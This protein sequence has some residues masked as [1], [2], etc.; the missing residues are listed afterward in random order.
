LSCFSRGDLLWFFPVALCVAA[1][2]AAGVVFGGGR[3][4]GGRF[5]L[6]CIVQRVRVLESW[7]RFMSCLCLWELVSFSCRGVILALFFFIFI[8]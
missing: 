8:P 4:H 5:G 1:L 7:L 3:R 6:G 2:G